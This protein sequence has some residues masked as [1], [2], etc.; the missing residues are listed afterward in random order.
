MF[1]N[2]TVIQRKRKD[3]GKCIMFTMHWLAA[4]SVEVKFWIF[5]FLYK[6]KIKAREIENKKFSVIA[7]I[8]R[9]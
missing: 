1:L 2:I 4:L 3:K 9:L 5:C 8:K 6:K 7:I